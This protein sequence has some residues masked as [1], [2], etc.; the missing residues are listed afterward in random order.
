M[1]VKGTYDFDQDGLSEILIFKENHLRLVEID[2]K[3][4]H[5]LLW[6]LTPEHYSLKDAFIFDYQNN[7][8]ADLI[9][10]AE[11]SPGFRSKDT[12]WL[13][14]FSWNGEQFEPTGIKLINSQL[15]H[16]NNVD[17]ESASKML[18]V[19][20]G[21]PSRTVFLV[22]FNDSGTADS[23]NVQLPQSV[24]NGIGHLFARFMNVGGEVHLAVFSNEND[25]LNTVLFKM[26]IAPVVIAEKSLPLNN[27]TKLLGPAIYKTD[28]DGDQTEELQ[29]PFLNGEVETLSYIDSAL[30]LASSK[31]TGKELFAVP[32]TS[33]PETINNVLLSRVESGLMIQSISHEEKLDSIVIIPDDTLNLGDTLVYK[34]TADT[35]SGFYSF[36]WLTQPPVS[37]FFDPTNGNITWIPTRKQLGLHQFKYFVEIR[38][39][40]ELI[41]DMDNLGDRHRMVPVVEE[42]EVLYTIIVMDTTKPPVVYVHPPYEPYMVSVHTPSKRD[43][44][45]RF[46]FNGV[47]PFHVMVDELDIPG[48]EQ[49]IHS[50][51]ANLGRATENKSVEFSYSSNKD[52][53]ANFMTLTI[54]HNLEKNTIHA[55][56]EPFLDTVSV[57]LNPADWKSELDVYPTYNFEGFPESMRLGES[58]NGISLYESERNQTSKNNSYI[59]IQTPMGKDRHN[60]TIT[61][62][63]IE[64][65]NING[66]VTT[67]SSGGEKVSTAII[68]SGEFYPFNI[69]SEVY[70]DAD[71]AKRVKEM[72][73]KA[74][75]YMGV[76]SAVVDSG[77]TE[78]Q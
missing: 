66:D 61:L 55:R 43:G 58:D 60:M 37:A 20:A 57:T 2:Q 47:P 69:K 44:G 3:G 27:A 52:S 40:D 41:S 71:F 56:I 74:L 78:I 65:W 64:L 67:D 36:R 24:H 70:S 16:P 34:A 1:F 35:G 7:G 25:L 5:Q 39:T 11:Y 62:S 21:N 33:S 72:K 32:D 68:F 23:I 53:L 73:F 15:M 8:I 30:T 63:P 46:I 48:Q 54:D 38:L 75:E 77:G 50:I 9:V 10:C 6:G 76:D 42:K 18:S 19:T 31:F 59:S 28:F 51:G 49:V 45:K 14:L 26:D 12:E 17:Y 13:K 29:L 4:Q 22:Q